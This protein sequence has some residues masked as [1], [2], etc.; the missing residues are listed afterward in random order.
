[1]TKLLKTKRRRSITRFDAA[2]GTRADPLRDYFDQLRRYPLLSAEE[3]TAIARQLQDVRRR[4]RR[5][6]LG[7]HYMVL[8]ATDLLRDVSQGRSRADRVLE[9]TVFDAAEYREITAGLPHVVW[10]LERL[11]ARNRHDATRLGGSPAV[12]WQP[13][14]RRLK[15]RCREAA[16]L[17]WQ[18]KL[19]LK[20]VYACWQRLR[21][22]HERMQQLEQTI[23]SAGDRQAELQGELARLVELAGMRPR[24]LGRWILLTSALLSRYDALKHRLA[25]HNLRLVVSIAKHYTRDDPE[26]LDLIQEGNAGLL[27]AAD[28]FEPLGYRFTT[29]AT[30]WIKQAIVR[31]LAEQQGMI[32]L[33]R[34]KLRSL[35]RLHKSRN[36][37]VKQ[38][39][40]S[41][42]VEEEVEACGLERHDAEVL[43]SFDRPF[44]SLD[45]AAPGIEGT[46]G[47]LIED[48]QHDEPA[49]ELNRK[50]LCQLVNQVLVGLKDRERQVIELRFGLTDNQFR[51]LDEVGKLLGVSGERVRQIERRAVDKLRASKQG[52]SLRA[53]L[54]P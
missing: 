32:T 27:R 14:A 25:R 46:L 6:L 18:A 2:R 39:G 9:T 29:Y 48:K 24:A 11:V 33:P 19:R 47:E 42:T 54:E 53:F 43:L 12:A 40:R 51:T 15:A 4:L 16:T 20:M 26:L 31:S 21:A 10:R 50:A 34:E 17:V 52:A 38:H 41:P 35:H 1:M 8:G 5:A 36:E 44:L 37:W 7:N 28:K 3:E 22:I 13:Y 45:L 30:W 49:S 23:P